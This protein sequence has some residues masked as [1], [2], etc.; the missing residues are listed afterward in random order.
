VPAGVA[1]ADGTRPR[2]HALRDERFG[3]ESRGGWATLTASR[4]VMDAS[5]R[6]YAFMRHDPRVSISTRIIDWQRQHGRHDLPWQGTRDP[7]R[8]WLAEVMLQQTQVATVIP[9]YQRFLERFADVRA[10]AAA[11]S[12]DVMAVWA[13]LG[14]Y[15]RARNLQRC[16]QV[17][18]SEHGG[19]FPRTAD[20]LARLPGIGRSTAAAIAVFANG[21]RAAILDGNVKRVFARHFGIE[22]DPGSAP[23]ERELWRRA[24][25]EL[26]AAGVPVADATIA[27]TALDAARTGAP[28]AQ[29]PPIVAY[30]QG[31]MDLGATLCTRHRPRCGDC[32]LQASCVAARQDRVHELPSPR[33]LKQRPLR[34]ATLAL[35]TDAAGA[36][37]LER[38]AAQGIWGGLFSLPEFDVALSQPA[39]LAAIEQ[40]FALQA[41]PVQQLPPR[42]H[43]FTHYRLEMRPCLLRVAGAGALADGAGMLWLARHDIAHAPLPAPIRRLLVEAAA[44]PAAGV[45]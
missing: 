39:L 9:Y 43:E 26:P 42:R 3:T 41:T 15:S 12:E 24:A 29:T 32:P 37:L 44:L 16:A 23:V 18:V 21:E 22:G 13:G 11:A 36:V 40:R 34:S 8:I 27:D 28:A 25:A 10:L 30:T 5:E 17:V 31:L 2:R 14:Y 33:A 1:H 45:T 4:F 7:Y 38:R 19:V 20:E 35:I 6:P